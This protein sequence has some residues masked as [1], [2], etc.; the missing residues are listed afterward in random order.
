M[1][2]WERYEGSLYSEARSV[3][4]KLVETNP[5]LI[6]S[7]GYGLVLPK[8]PIGWYDLRLNA[9]DWPSRLLQEC[10]AACARR[11]GADRV[12]AF[13]GRSTSYARILRSVDWAANGVEARLI[14][15]IDD[16]GRARKDVNSA[17][18]RAVRALLEDGHL[19]SASP[20]IPLTAEKLGA[21]SGRPQA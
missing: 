5:L 16:P 8:E 3:L 9:R 17:I 6:L 21:G 2:A 7:G 4:R 11:L 14:T 15:P 19:G 13:A 10:L 18:G 20:M 1:P 12:V